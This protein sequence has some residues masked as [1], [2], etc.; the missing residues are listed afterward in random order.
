MMDDYEVTGLMTLFLYGIDKAPDLG[1]STVDFAADDL[2]NQVH[3]AQP[4]QQYFDAFAA[5]LRT[6]RVPE[7]S[8]Q[9]VNRWTE[10]EVLDF[11]ARLYRKL[12]D[13]RPWPAPRFRKLDLDQ[14]P[15]FASARGIARIEALPSMV[16]GMFVTSFDKVET[17]AGEL[18]VLLLQLRSGE[19]VAIMGS[20]GRGSTVFT[21]LAKTADPAATLAHFRDVTRFDDSQVTALA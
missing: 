9:F 21:L 6:G 1:A 5:V 20:T 11:L 19:Q 2:L 15:S 7:H 18:P 13:A 16:E 12:D 17:G 14:W 10:G 8:M 4:P 3:Y